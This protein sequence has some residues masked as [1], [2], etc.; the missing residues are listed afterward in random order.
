MGCCENC[1]EICLERNNF[2]EIC[3]GYREDEK[4][5]WEIATKMSEIDKEK[6]EAG[7]FYGANWE[8]LER[9]KKEYQ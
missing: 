2:Y 9:F 7:Y 5:L 8:D 3:I 1:K 4:T 6:K